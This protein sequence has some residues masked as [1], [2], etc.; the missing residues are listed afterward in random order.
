M[1]IAA[2]SRA[3]VALGNEPQGALARLAWRIR[4]L[5]WGLLFFDLWRQLEAERRRYQDALNVVLMGELLGIPMMTTTL[6][7][8]LLPYLLPDLSG[9]KR[10]ELEE[11]EILEEAPVAH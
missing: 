3:V 4:A 1:S 2:A 11:H 6:T 7:L 8:R 5:F 10:R 9:W